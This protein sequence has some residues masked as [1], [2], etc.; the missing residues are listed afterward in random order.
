MPVTGLESAEA[1]IACA[2]ALCSDPAASADRFLARL[3]DYAAEVQA[4]LALSCMDSGVASSILSRT[5]A[6][7]TLLRQKLEP[8]SMPVLK[9]FAVLRGQT[10]DALVPGR[11]K[12]IS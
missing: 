4:M 11:R 1:V 8:V 6:S 12:R 9:C 7:G 2:Q 3:P 10:F 5:T